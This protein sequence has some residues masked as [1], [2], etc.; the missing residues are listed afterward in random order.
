MSVQY[1][2]LLGMMALLILIFARVPVAI[3]MGLVGT[4]GYAAISGFD[5]AF[6][7]LGSTP[8]EMGSAYAL[9]VV[10]LF[11]LM[12]ALASGAG[13][14]SQL[15]SSVRALFSGARGGPAYATLGASAAFGAVCGSSL[16]VAA[17][18]SRIA[19]PEM[20]RAGYGDKLITGVIAAGGSLGILIPPSI[21]LVIYA[22]I[23]E[24]S[25]QKLFAAALI[26]SILLT[27]FYGVVLGWM[28]HRKDNHEEA[29][30][31]IGWKGRL[32]ALFSMWEIILLFGVS[33]GGIYL[34]WFSPTESAAVGSF[35]AL[36]LGLLRRRLPLARVHAAFVETILISSMLFL[37][38]LCAFIFSYFVVLTELPHTLVEWTRSLH[39]SPAVIMLILILFYIVMGCFLDGIGMVLITVPVFF[40]LVT[41]AGFDPV[42]FGVVLVLVVELGLIH[43]PVGMNIFVI[44][45]QA[46]DIPL[47][48]IYRGVIPF[49]AAPIA[50]L[51]L[52]VAFP[53]IALWFPGILYR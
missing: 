1:I 22:I 30:P 45:A 8:F 24:Q 5:K 20:R 49:L 14:S 31:N 36:L 34:G 3:A 38:V 42:W 4:L 16:A 25:V 11:V 7:V 37:V 32:R 17:T 44:R 33:I 23:A 10:P 46:P 19:L 13:I 52:L 2:G 9:S 50:L 39:A 15:F 51:L 41:E 12:G 26:P 18:M 27:L 48:V 29:M 53:Q 6:I 28:V 21:I 43:P 47:S 35:G 40:P